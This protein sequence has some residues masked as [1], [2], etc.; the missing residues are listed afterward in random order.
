MKKLL[1][2]I[3]LFFLG[4]S[5]NEKYSTNEGVVSIDYL[6]NSKNTQ[7][8]ENNYD[9]YTLDINT[10]NKDFSNIYEYQINH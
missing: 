4:C 8:F 6:F 2:I 9:S 5:S 1:L 7:W 3:T 10:L